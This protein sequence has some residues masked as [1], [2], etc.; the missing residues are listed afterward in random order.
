MAKILLK[1]IIFYHLYFNSK[2]EDKM[3]EDFDNQTEPRKINEEKENIT[4]NNWHLIFRL[5]SLSLI[6]V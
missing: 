4:T 5:M 3:F 6:M 1:L 2:Q